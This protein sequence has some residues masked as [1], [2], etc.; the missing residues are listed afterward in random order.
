MP[1]Q[2]YWLAELDE[3]AQERLKALYDRIR[4]QGVAGRQTQGLYH[5]TLGSRGLEGEAEHARQMEALCGALRSFELRIS[6]VGLFGQTVLFLG[7]N[8]NEELLALHRTFFPESGR[9]DHEWSPHV[10]LL[11][12][13]AEAVWKAL[14]VV[15]EAFEPFCT[16]IEAVSLYAFYPQR[17][18]CRCVLEKG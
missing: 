10:T 4:E 8:P 18:I 2:L 14:P 6:H 3:Q 11:M 13:E 7:P 9:G 16:R 5:L 1:E 15:A 17:F 12:D